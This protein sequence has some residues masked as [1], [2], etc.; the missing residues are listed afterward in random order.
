MKY[1]EFTREVKALVFP[2][3]EAPNLVAAHN[4]AIVQA[5]VDIQKWV[6]CQQQD[7]KSLHPQCATYYR[8]GLTYLPAPE[9][10]IKKVQ[11]V[12]R[13]NPETGLEDATADYDWCSAVDY[14]E[15]PAFYMD[16]YLAR[17]RQIGSCIPAATFFGLSPI[18][19]AKGAYR[20]PVPTNAGLPTNLRPLPLGFVYPQDSTDATGRALSG[21]WAKERGNIVIAPWIQSTE[22]VVVIWDGIKR[23]WA[24][25][26]EVSENPLVMQA[27][28]E[29]LRW[30]HFKNWD[31]D[32]DASSAANAAYKTTLATLMHECREQTRVR[33]EGSGQNEGASHARGSAGSVSRLYYNTA[34]S[35]TAE[36][37]AGFD[38]A[39]VTVQI[40]EGTVGSTVSVADANRM[41][42]DQA[43][44]D[45]EAQLDCSAIVPTFTNDSDVTATATCEDHPSH[46][47]DH[48]APT[49]SVSTATVKAGTVTGSTQEAAN[50][51]AEAKAAQEAIAGLDCTFYSKESELT[52]TCDTDPSI[53]VTLPIAEGL[54][55]STL[56]EADA[57]AQAE[58]EVSNAA[59]AQ[60]Y[61]DGCHE[62]VWNDAQQTFRSFDCNVLEVTGG[63]LRPVIVYAT[64]RIAANRV[65]GTD[66]LD[67]NQK[68]FAQLAVAADDP[69][70]RAYICATLGTWAP[71]KS[72]TVDI[73]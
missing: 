18:S 20:I 8:C 57:D 27:V 62:Q 28:Q 49:G 6:E 38:G 53:T 1:G 29:W 51:A 41:A 26:E 66:K 13:I 44:A 43:K 37:G 55:S 24:D 45:A 67:A 9:G 12:D 64:F 4:K 21:V 59:M 68:A 14:Y 65:S 52:A 50:A 73:L 36:C 61:A 7:N 46:D 32:Y 70:R 22:M 11:V 58:A 63:A 25:D 2:A 16:R 40:P 54:K 17:S 35:Y 10:V 71:A 15:V 47:E 69:G 72:V 19:C 39:A 23:T 33:G 42:A 30:D 31:K 3:G 56:S 5:L 60:L 34:Q 48:P